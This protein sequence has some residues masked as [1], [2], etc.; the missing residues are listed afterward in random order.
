MI[1]L[2]EVFKDGVDA[3]MIDLWQQCRRKF[4]NRII[5]GL[6]SM[7]SSVSTEF[8]HAI[9]VALEGYLR[10]TLSQEQTIEAF[11]ET[12]LDKLTDERRTEER[13]IALLK[14]YFKAFPREG[15]IW[16]VLAVEEPF[17][18]DIGA[19]VPYCGRVDLVVQERDTRVI[20]VVD[21]KTTTAWGD[22]YVDGYQIS[23]QVDGYILHTAEK[24][25]SCDGMV[26]NVLVSSKATPRC[27][28]FRVYR[29]AEQLEFWKTGTRY[30][31]DEMVDFVREHYPAGEE[32]G[33]VKEKYP[34]SRGR[35]RDYNAKCVYFD[36]CRFCDNLDIASS[37]FT[38]RG[39]TPFRKGDNS[40]KEVKS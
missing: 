19:K 18:M 7:Y 9:H 13:G 2:D 8:G 25:G 14:A 5:R 35:C 39:W 31:V 4:Y 40:L 15:E 33:S 10:G 34:L 22:F 21:H 30:V 16:D 12:Y 24:Y 6:D 32:E 28:R 1:P 29:T 26:L 36:L 38:K 20:M 23:T 37:G 27:E 17:R 11:K 3:T